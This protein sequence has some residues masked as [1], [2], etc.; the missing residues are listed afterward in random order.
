MRVLILL[1]IAIFA[2]S[3]ELKIAT[4]N[5]ENLFDDNI[6][7]SEYKDFKD[8]TWNTAKYIQKLNNISRVIKALDAD[9]IS[10]VEIENSS[11]LKQ[12]AMKSGYKFYEFATNKNAPVGLGVM[13]KYPILSSQKIVI[14]NLKTRPILVSEISFGGET[15]KFFS[16]HFP[17]AKNS[18]KDR[19]TAANTMIK[20]VKN[21]KNSIIL[22]DLN[23]NYGYGFLLNE[24]NG[25]FKNLW[26]FLGNRDRSSYK[27]G[28]AIDHIMLQNSFFNGNIRYK[29]SSFGV[30]KPSF[31]S[32]QK[33][34]DHYA[35]YVV[36]TSEFSDSPVLKK[37]IDEIYRVSDERAEVAGVVI[38][39][40]KF[41]YILADESKRG[42]YVYEKN[43]KLPLGT[44]V[45]AIVNK[46]DLYKG[47]MQISS[48]SYKN[49]DT[50][51]DTDI[52]KFMISQNEIKSARSGDVVSNLKIDV[53][54]GFTSINGE[55]L[56]VFSRSKSIKDGQNLVYK[57]ALVW[58][59]KGEKELIVE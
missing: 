57:N 39:I 50:A 53:K 1:F 29:N 25:E 30:F 5:V 28:G 36:L 40:D 22:G 47:N 12:L 38:Y 4:Y 44:K 13:S 17:A 49:V 59:Y 19:K 7:G 23:S 58:S 41:G 24:L 33:F 46:T 54:N 32:S 8:G 56:R 21:E 26:E 52:S 9:F 15:I 6:D 20:A 18:L 51:F 45:E 10:V 27:K 35:I 14:P 37:S 43:P 42:I 48:I 2:I 3:A 31:L 55:K 34:S 16:A 11:V